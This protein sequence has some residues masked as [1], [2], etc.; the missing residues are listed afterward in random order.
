MR[1]ERETRAGQPPAAA[2]AVVVG[3]LL[4]S[5]VGL[6]AVRDRAYPRRP[7]DATV[8]YV[9]SGPVLQ[10][11]ALSF[12]ALLA[13]VYWIRAIQHYGGTRR[14][15]D[16][17]KRYH[18]LEPLLSLAVSLDP[19][20]NIVY[21]FGAIFLAE[22]WP[23]GPGRPDQA[24]ALLERGLR[25]RPGNWR[26][27]QDIGFIY[28]WW[29][30]DYEQAAAWFERAAAQP[31]APPWL[32]ALAASTL[33]EGGRREA[34]RALWTAI[35]ESAEESWLR[36]NAERRLRQLDAL[37][38]RDRLQALVDRYA[39]AGGS[40]PFTWARLIESGYLAAV[41]LDPEGAPFE[42]GEFSGTVEIAPD[43]PL[44]PMPAEPPA[45]R[46]R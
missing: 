34:S 12:D 22:P 18:L 27:M 21:R 8:L 16:P 28:Y 24:I 3:V 42:L 36:Q 7:V 43:S 9:R 35:R 14:S 39:A 4:V 33:A 31:G 19:H 23:G 40:R 46:A 41:P 6:A 32:R 44:Q 25:A 45:A 2:L 10:R 11:M 26:Y 20:F 29:L 5:S 15:A 37:D 17:A 1:G 30:H 13:D 38:Q